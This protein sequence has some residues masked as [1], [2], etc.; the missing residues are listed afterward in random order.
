M[1]IFACCC[2]ELSSGD[3]KY[4]ARVLTNFVP[5]YKHMIPGECYITSFSRKT[6]EKFVFF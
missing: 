2:S 1:V 4:D 3:A 5:V 6:S